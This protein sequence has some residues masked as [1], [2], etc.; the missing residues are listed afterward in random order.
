MGITTPSRNAESASNCAGA[1]RPPLGREALAVSRRL[2]AAMASSLRPWRLPGL[3]D[4]FAAALGRGKGRCRG[5]RSRST[6]L[7]LPGALLFLLSLSL[8]LSFEANVARSAA[9][10]SAN[11]GAPA[12]PGSAG[13]LD[14]GLVDPGADFPRVSL[15]ASSQDVRVVLQQLAATAGINIVVDDSLAARIT[16]KLEDV[17]FDQA[18]QSIAK[19]AGATVLKDGGIY[20]V[21]NSR[22][23]YTQPPPPA[24]PTTVQ[25]LD[26]SQGEYDRVLEVVRAIAGSLEVQ[27]FPELKA[28]MIRGPYSQV[29][30]VRGAVEAFL[31]ARPGQPA[32]QQQI[33]RVVPLSYA[34]P[35][36]TASAVQGQFSGVR[37]VPVRGSNSLVVNGP[38]DQVEAVVGAIKSLDRTPAL[39]AFEVEMV[40]VDSDAARTLGIDW[41][42][43]QGSPVFSIGWKEADPAL[44]PGQQKESLTGWRPWTRTSLQIVT[45]LKMLEEKGY[46]KVL[47]RPSLTTLENKTARMVTGDRFTILITQSSGSGTWQQIQFI[48]AAV[49]L[50][51]TPRLDADGA[52]VVQL[53]PQIST[54]TG[55]SR[56]GYPIMS[57]RETQTTVRLNDGETLVIGGL[58]RDETSK[59]Q[60]GLPG[61]SKIPILGSLFGASKE[62]NRRTELVILVAPRVVKGSRVDLSGDIGSGNSILEAV[63]SAE[64]G[65]S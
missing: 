27:G 9:A 18:L 46:A 48:D 54:I 40:E 21:L 22:S 30:A 1:C 47:A 63:R 5:P 35:Y 28:I 51:L 64:K 23:P 24:E 55:Y 16:V 56:E 13:L 39:I 26:V 50:E 29:N 33:L 45:Q 6:I 49:R 52:I 7:T 10:G 20:L 62:G 58:I 31:R 19:A 8:S 17:P 3:R 14:P 42:G 34:D 15:E 41:L 61:L 12:Q 57:T 38:P 65:Q 44:P 60:A 53:L 36:E 32:P 37:V 11:L 43:A 25:L 4:S 59:E 2:R